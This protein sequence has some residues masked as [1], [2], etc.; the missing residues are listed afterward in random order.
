MES[1]MRLNMNE[2]RLGCSPSVYERIREISASSGISCYPSIDSREVAE[3]IA[4]RHKVRAEQVIV[5]NGSIEALF[6]ICLIHSRMPVVIPSPSY[7]GYYAMARQ[8]GIE[9]SAPMV[10]LPKLDMDIMMNSIEKGK[11]Q[12]VLISQPNNPTGTSIPKKLLMDI[13]IERPD[14]IFIIDEAYA[15][16]AGETFIE[17]LETI[18]NIIVTR[19]FSKSYGLAGLRVGYVVLPV[20]QIDKISKYR[21]PYGV[22]YIS[23]QAAL[24]ALDDEEWHFKAVSSIR[25]EREYLSQE[26]KRLGLE[27]LPSNAN[28]ILVKCNCNAFQVVENL[29]QKGI[30]VRYWDTPELSEYFRVTVGKRDENDAFIHELASIVR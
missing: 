13:I 28:F 26:L 29:K 1:I 3:K 10:Y 17:Q 25:T 15:E 16:F 30:L 2:N 11:K 4:L 12:A 6:W 21:F 18:Q 23:Q 14:C 19:S 7:H 24:A 9:C 20:N 5:Y 27:T 8:L 22:D